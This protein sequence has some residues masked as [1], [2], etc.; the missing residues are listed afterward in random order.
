MKKILFLFLFIPFLGFSQAV[1][2]I[3]TVGMAFVPD[4]VILTAGE[5][6]YINP[7]SGHNAVEV[8]E[9]TWLANG[10]SSN[11]GFSC[12]FGTSLMFQT[13]TIAKTYYYVCQPHVASMSMKGVI[14]A[15]PIP[16]YGCMD[17]TACNY[18]STATH[19]DTSCHFLF[20]CTDPVACTYDPTA[21]CDYGSCL[22]DYGCTDVSAPNYDPL[23]TC[24]DGSCV[25]ANFSTD[26]VCELSVTTFTNLS[27]GNGLSYVWDMGDGGTGTYVNGTNQNSENPQYIY[28][29]GNNVVGYPATLTITDSSGYQ[30]DVLINVLVL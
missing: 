30:H 15:L 24:D 22:V 17:S 11:G 14:I 12:G 5:I 27:S 28:A 2:T 7:G 20:G 6:V 9:A 29:N 26:T 21:V 13:D 16:I 18:D 23:A 3:N 10:N 4:T 8:S 25:I 1:D 19:S